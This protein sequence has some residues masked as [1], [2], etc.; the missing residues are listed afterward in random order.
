MKNYIKSQPFMVW[1]TLFCVACLTPITYFVYYSF[2]VFTSPWREL[3]SL[4]VAL[5]VASFIMIYT[6]RR[7]KKVALYYSLFEI[8]VSA[9]Y[10]IQTISQSE[11]ISAWGLIPA[12]G[13]TLVLPISV[14]FCANELDKD[15]A[16]IK[17]VAEVPKEPIFTRAEFIEQMEVIKKQFAENM[18]AVPVASPTPEKRKIKK[19]IVRK[20]SSLGPTESPGILSEIKNIIIEDLKEQ[21]I[22]IPAPVED[23]HGDNKGVMVKTIYAKKKNNP[24][25][26]NDL[27]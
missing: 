1:V 13:F 23:L 24:F 26:D 12:L 21:G 6:V 20:N 8:S 9:Y 7:N 27:K 2:S 3:A 25:P 14:Y 15:E 5:I 11:T 22:Q 18:Q 10:Y 16:E 4:G 17:T 19:V